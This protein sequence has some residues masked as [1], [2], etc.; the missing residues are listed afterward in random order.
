M[1]INVAATEHAE[2]PGRINEVVQ[3][4]TTTAKVFTFEKT[5][6]HSYT[7]FLCSMKQR[8]LKVCL[9]IEHT[10]IKATSLQPPQSSTNVAFDRVS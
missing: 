2:K 4:E 9:L 8:F 3:D 6:F 10:L 7:G 1:E 5:V